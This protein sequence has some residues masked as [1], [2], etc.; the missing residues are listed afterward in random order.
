MLSTGNLEEVISIVESKHNNP[1]NILGMHKVEHILNFEIVIRA[2]NP[3]AI[4]IKVIN[5]DTNKKYEMKKI[6]T[7]GFFEVTTDEKDFFKYKLEIE[8]FDNYIYETFDPYS[9]LPQISDFDIHLFSSGTHYEVYNKLGATPLV[10]G[11]IEGVLFGVWAPNAMRVS[12]I[13]EFNNWDGRRNP[14]RTI[15]VSGVY[16]IFIPGLKNFDK[17]KFEIRT[18]TGEIVEKQDPY[19]FFHEHR[20]SHTSLIYN[21][22][23]YKWKDEKWMRKR[24]SGNI[25]NT[26]INIYEVN[27]GSWKKPEGREYFSFIELKD[28]LIPYVK[29]MGYTHIEVMPI[30]EFPFDGS[31]GYQVTGYYAPTSRFGT[32][33]DL[34]DFIDECHNNNIGVI[35][36]WVPAH[37]PKDPHGLAKFDGTSLYEH[38]NP[39]QGEHPDWGTLI[40]NL[41]RNEVKNFLIANANYWL[42][43]YH[44]DGLRVDAVASMLYLDYGKDD[45]IPNI[46]GGR[47]NLESI[48]FFRHLNSIL[49]KM[50]PN[51]LMCAEES[52]AWPG[53]TLPPD[54][55]GLGFNLKWNMGWMNDYLGYIEKDCIFRKYHH[56]QLTFSMV[57]AYTEN[58]I[59]VLSHDEVVHGKKSLIDKMP[60]DIWQKCAN[61][62]LTFGFMMTHPGKKLTFMGSEFGQFQEWSEKN[63]LDWFLLEYDHHQGIQ[64]FVRDMN[65]IYKDLNALWMTDFD[66]NGFSWISC[67]DYE[68]S[69][70]IYERKT[71]DPKESLIIFCNFT[72]ETYDEYESYVPYKGVYSEIINSDDEK[73]GG[74]GVINAIDIASKEVKFSEDDSISNFIKIKLPPLGVAI[75]KYL[76]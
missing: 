21:I 4:T 14:M 3:N 35:L 45:W 59:L 51:I 11:G 22:N 34:M 60:G 58:F 47:E 41:G 62:R 32:P 54:V 57:Y 28:T 69:V 5:Q 37:F 19:G 30:T 64:K 7:D 56:N 13:G 71:K 42:K 10:V 2:F 12:V 46:Y 23:G 66:K 72:P 76:G 49:Y 65:F 26:P 73:Y 39:L 50:H 31:W 6:H 63:S 61:L 52:T 16:E 53:I 75:F 18:S 33:H 36:D 8:T 48:E 68:N 55:G 1:H 27:L 15:G 17:Y 24:K 40:F 9:F 74:S 43:E 38:S 44:I 20:P 25:L 67:D 29:E 70:V